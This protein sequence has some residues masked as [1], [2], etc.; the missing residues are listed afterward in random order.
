MRLTMANHWATS[1]SSFE[2][3]PPA[4]IASPVESTSAMPYGPRSKRSR[5]VERSPRR[6]AVVDEADGV[7]VDAE[8]HQA[9]GDAVRV[10]L[11]STTSAR[12]PAATV[13]AT[14]CIPTHDLPPPDSPNSWLMRAR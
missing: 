12:S 13:S 3:T 2:L 11:Q 4:A 10:V 7:L 5:P 6:V 9:L 14:A 1:P 8:L